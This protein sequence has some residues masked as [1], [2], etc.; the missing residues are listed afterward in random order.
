MNNKKDVINDPKIREALK[1]LGFTD[2]FINI[3][4]TLLVEGELNAHDLSE[5]TGVPYS[6]IYEIINDM[7]KRDLITKID[8]RPST[9]IAR[10]PDEMF[11][12]VKKQRD[13]EFEVS[14][15]QSRGFLK[16]LFGEKSPAKKVEFILYEGQ[17]PC[18]DHLRNI[19]NS[20][21]HQLSIVLQDF[22]EIYPIIKNNLDFLRTKGVEIKILVEERF[23]N[24]NFVKELHEHAKIR[25]SV[26]VNHNMLVSDD[27]AALQSVKGHFNLAKPSELD[28]VIF[29]STQSTYVMY[30]AEIFMRKWNKATE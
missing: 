28:Y 27:K 4:T 1:V 25:F 13:E 9:F 26:Q 10:D 7:I 2:Y 30:I 5:F 6:R 8:G 11:K 24:E 19:I 12:S 23:R 14:L 22:D 17:A 29:S 20:T 18:R 3:Y 15:S 16:E 21:A